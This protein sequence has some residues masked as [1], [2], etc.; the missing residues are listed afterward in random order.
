M[1]K[2]TLFVN[3]VKRTIIANP[4]TTL[5]DVIRKQVLLTGTK[6][7]C[8]KGE[9][10][11]C[12]VILNG[13]V[14][15]SCITRFK[16]VP[17]ESEIITI[18]GVGDNDHLHPLQLAWMVHGAAQCGFCS[19]GFIVSAKVLLDNNSNPTREDVRAWFQK[20]RNVCRCT[21]YKPL[22]DAVME[23]A[24]LMRGE[25]TKEELW[26]KLPKGQSLLGSNA[27]RPSALAKVTGTWDF[28]AD[29]GLKL[30]EDTLHIK[31][32]QATVSHAN[33]LSI[34][35]SEAEKM[36][37]V[38]KVLTYKD[39]PGTN[40][41]NGLAFPTNKGDGLERPILCDKKIF[42]F[43][44]AIA[45][46]L[47]DTPCQAEAAAAKVK[48]EIE[49]LPAYMS[50]PAAMDEDAM[51]IHPGTPNIYFECGTIKGEDT[52]P[53]MD[54]L[55]YVVEDDSYV[56]RQPHLPL[57]PDVGF[58]YLNEEG[59]LI[60]HSKSIGLHLH[61]AM[62]ADGIG[63]KL[64]D[65]KI[66]Q[67]PTGGT[68]GYKFSPTMEGLLGV[69]ALL[70]KR[71]VY[72]EFNM[73][74]QIT[75]TGKRSPFFMHLKL[76]ADKDGIFK[77]LET[78]WSVDHGPYCEFGD[79][80]TTRGSQF[81]G[82]GYGIPNIRGNG[83]TVATNHAWGSAFRGYGSPQSL[84]AS[85]V[86]VDK[87]AKKMGVDPLELRYKNVYREGDKT[88]TGCDPDVIALPG[89]IE[90]IM[91]RYKAAKAKAAEKNVKGGNMKYG[92]GTSLLIYGCGL[93][94]PDTSNAWAELTKEGVT[95]GNSWQDH[96]QGADMGT[97]TLAHETLRPIGIEPEQIKLVMNDMERTPD[98]GP[99]GGSRSNVLTGNATRVACE[100]LLAAMKKDDGTYMTYDEMVAAGKELKYAGKWTAPCTAPDPA[101]GQGNPFPTYM[102]GVLLSE[103]EV[104]TTTGKVKVEKL[105]IAADI[106]TIVN[107]LVCDGQIYGGLAQGIGLALSEDFEDLKK[108]TTLTGC[109]IPQVKD[110]T[111]DIEIIY[112]ETPRPLGPYGASGNGEMPLSAPHASIVNAIYD[113]TGVQIT[114]LPARPEK[115]LAALEQLK[116]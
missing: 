18:E 68:F 91:P 21:G 89:L 49:E 83:R 82:A 33:I 79:L 70:T 85:E 9:C 63:V 94:G 104:D 1:L 47:A 42:Q 12:S 61:A 66:V 95:I 43:G 51:E 17:D 73:Y 29:L 60:I 80:V 103:V 87:L 93:D 109:G 44:D 78:D 59:K 96:G 76:G 57:E 6:V 107:K 14:V 53:L 34:D 46:V 101:T 112:Q 22:I 48:V 35:T 7:G 23:A 56:G 97:L 84:F 31:L 77:A 58:A 45:M 90:K 116:K 25:V 27:V 19:P 74:Q 65:L 81:M 54:T 52:K 24:R 72:L 88:P 62:V 75:Y 41:I 2:K 113:A 38:F 71:V 28:G 32:V 55:E 100:N 40:R 114:H 115:V 106:G 86:L 36:P 13:K 3:G 111:D 20:N 108:H 69:A 92:V 5:A 50:A 98:S 10:G 15:R 26:Y 30:P 105:T 102:Y 16:R 64:D 110:V 67:N 37:G 4:E 99:S 8:G 39:V 11:A